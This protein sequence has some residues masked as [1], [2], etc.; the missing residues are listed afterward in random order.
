MY[1]EGNAK[2]AEKGTF[3]QTLENC[4]RLPTQEEILQLEACERVGKYQKVKITHHYE[5][6]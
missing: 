6:Y 3:G 1:V 2:Y 5:I 4:L